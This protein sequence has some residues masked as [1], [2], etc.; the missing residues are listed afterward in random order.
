MDC[1]LVATNTPPLLAVEGV[2]VRAVNIGLGRERI[3]LGAPGKMTCTKKEETA[4]Q[5]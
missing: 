3:D 4:E 2:V 1:P 5:N